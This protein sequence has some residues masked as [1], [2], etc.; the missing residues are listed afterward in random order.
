[1]KFPSTPQPQNNSLAA[2]QRLTAGVTSQAPQ[3]NTIVPE[4]GTLRE[5]SIEFDFT[6]QKHNNSRPETLNTNVNVN[7]NAN[8]N[9]YPP[10]PNGM[11]PEYNSPR[12][13]GSR[14]QSSASS[15]SDYGRRYLNG[16][17][18]S[19]ISS[20]SSRETRVRDTTSSQKSKND[21]VNFASLDTLMEDLG[22]LIDVK[23]PNG[24]VSNASLQVQNVQNVPDKLHEVR[25]RLCWKL[26]L[27]CRS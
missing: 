1:L 16:M 12:S 7:N 15:V 21:G 27:Y 24:D 10:I 19:S 11:P 22:N 26:F 23:K 9:N 8:P 14:V 17:S 25:H 3:S 6:I 13:P 4:M 20:A 5:E 2:P 18:V